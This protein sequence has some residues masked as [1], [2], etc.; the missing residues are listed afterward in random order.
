MNL[1]TVRPTRELRVDFARWAVAQTPKVRTCSTTDFAV[2][3]HLFT[4]MPERL[5]IGSLVDGHRYVSPV[6]DERP[7]R[8]TAVPGEPLPAVPDSAY[9]PDATPLD[10][11]SGP[12]VDAAQLAGDGEP[13]PAVMEEAVTV[14]EAAGDVAAGGDSSGPT[15]PPYACG[16]CPR[17]FT[18]VRGRDTHHRQA[19]R[20]A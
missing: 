2:P 19:H 6:E 9:G 4:H 11:A 5:L 14:V 7:Q 17:T 10:P 15:S 13:A 3:P 16:L 12:Q 8:L 20:E 1:I 18:T